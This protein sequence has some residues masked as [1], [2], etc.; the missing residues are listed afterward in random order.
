MPSGAMKH[1]AFVAL[2]LVVM[3]GLIIAVDVLFLRDLFWARLLTNIGI[4]AV[5]VVVY[6]TVVQKRFR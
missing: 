3:G 4:V 2:Y 6:L 1:T 5:F